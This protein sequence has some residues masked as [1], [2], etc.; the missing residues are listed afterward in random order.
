MN[1]AVDI[2]GAVTTGSVPTT[3]SFLPSSVDGAGWVLHQ[4]S[5]QM[6]LPMEP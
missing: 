3:G 5:F 6:F 4:Q 2:S 1:G